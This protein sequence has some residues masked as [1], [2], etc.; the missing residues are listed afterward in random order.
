MMGVDASGTVVQIGD[1]TETDF[2]TRYFVD[3]SESEC[4]HAP[5]PNTFCIDVTNIVTVPSNVNI[6]KAA[7]LACTGLTLK[8]PGAIEADDR[9][10]NVGPYDGSECQ[11]TDQSGSIVE[12]GKGSSEER[13]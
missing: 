7:G 13:M 2:S 10:G 8:I 9:L 12:Y 5:L 1:G 11:G 3:P 6:V 4:G